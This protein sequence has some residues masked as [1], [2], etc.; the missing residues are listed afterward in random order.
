ML[1]GLLKPSAGRVTALG[2]DML[3]DRHS[4]LPRMNFSSPYVDLPHR[5]TVRQ[6]LRVFAQLYAVQDP[7]ARIQ[8]LA[9]ELDFDALL[10]RPAGALSA[11][12]KT[13]VA[14]AKALI[15]R[16][17]LLLLDEPT[18]SLDPDTADWVRSLLERY[19]AEHNATILLASHNMS[20]VERLCEQVLMMKQ[21]LIVDRGTP[22]ELI[23]RYGRRNLEEVFLDIARG[24]G[25]AAAD[26]VQE[27][28]LA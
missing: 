14:L 17:E 27:G 4:V 21:G 5:L 20:E 13:R 15:N 7:K 25:K 19:K 28:A 18:A 6:N 16:P 10:D 12:Q 1:L 24:Q 2:V 22:D 3:R 9:R 26:Y 8:E 23:A 11:G